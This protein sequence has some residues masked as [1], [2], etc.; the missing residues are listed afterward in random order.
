MRRIFSSV[1]FVFAAL[2]L[3]ACE[4]SEKSETTSSITKDEEKT[5]SSNSD[6][7]IALVMKT[8]TNPFF[9]AMEKG[10]RKAEK[11]LGITLL[12]K[13]AAQETSTAQQVSIV[14]RLVREGNVQAIVIAPS[15]SVKLIPSLK[16]AQDKGIYVINIDNSL[17]LAFSKKA[18]LEKVPFI[19]IDNEQSAYLSAKYIANSVKI[20]TEVGI[21]EGIREAENANQRKRGAMKAF[22]ENPNLKIVASETA[23]WKIDEGY[24]VAKE[25]FRKYPDIN[26]LFCANDMMAL[27]AIEY[28]KETGRKDVLVAA[29]DAIDDARLALKEGWLKVTIDQQPGKQG[30]LGV[31]LALDLIR[32]KDVADVTMLEGLVISE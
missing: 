5:A 16:K 10:A 21:L 30:Y 26:L 3:N 13:T 1:L 18:G 27:G 12:V 20:P 8:L 22:G 14:E 11:E 29:F 4:E 23:H 2:F 19:S 32:G 31:V 7:Q 28:L 6:I 25:M 17:D 9:I 24:E 15:D